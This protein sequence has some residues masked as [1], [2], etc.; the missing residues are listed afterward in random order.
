[1][2]E[3]KQTKSIP[4]LVGESVKREVLKNASAHELLDALE[5]LGKRGGGYLPFSVRERLKALS[6]TDGS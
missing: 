6:L 1:M 4:D 2:A 5:I 3:E